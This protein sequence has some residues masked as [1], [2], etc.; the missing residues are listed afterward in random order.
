MHLTVALGECADWVAYLRLCVE[1]LRLITT[2][3]KCTGMWVS[4][5]FLLPYV[6]EVGAQG[7]CCQAHTLHLDCLCRRGVA[8]QRGAGHASGQADVVEGPAGI[9][10]RNVLQVKGTSAP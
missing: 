1:L 2:C 8:G 9:M 4:P 10:G 6:G 5:Q 3:L 7:A